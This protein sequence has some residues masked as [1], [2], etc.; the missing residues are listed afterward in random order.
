MD[1]A[2]L[3]YIQDVITRTFKN[4]LTTCVNIKLIRMLLANKTLVVDACIDVPR[5]LSN[6]HWTFPFQKVG[7]ECVKW[8]SWVE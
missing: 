2:T 6:N 3:Q 7:A 1:R 4:E 5:P 8:A